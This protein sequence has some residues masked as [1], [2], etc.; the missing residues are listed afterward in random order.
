MTDIIIFIAALSVLVLVHEFGHYI[1]A[2]LNGIKV[3][4][5]GLGLPPRIFGKKIGET[6]FSLNALPIGGFCKLYG[7]DGDKQGNRAFNNKKPWQKFLVVV[8][9]VVMNL[10]MAV[11]IFSVVYGILGVPKETDVVKV[12]GVVENSPAAEAGL[13]EGDAV[14]SVEGIEVHEPAKLIE[15]VSKFKGKEVELMIKDAGDRGR[16]DPFCTSTGTRE[17]S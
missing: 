15:E 7:E 9:G 10:V 1:M 13:K 4:E 16:A 14:I 17:P 8:G 3:E 2:V 6:V 12:I 11:F 5:F